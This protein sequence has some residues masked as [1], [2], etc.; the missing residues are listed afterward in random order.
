ME[1][2]LVRNSY[3]KQL[4]APAEEA[5]K[6][7]RGGLAPCAVPTGLSILAR[8]P[9]AVENSKWLWHFQ[10]SGMPTGNSY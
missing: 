9:L 4:P 8:R 3:R 2:L 7:S 6:A 5:L 10:S 1:V